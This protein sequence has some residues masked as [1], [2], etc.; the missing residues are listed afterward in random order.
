MINRFRLGVTESYLC[1]VN[2][3][4]HFLYKVVWFYG[5]YLKVMDEDRVS[6]SFQNYISRVC[7][8]VKRLVGFILRWFGGKCLARN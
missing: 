5:S 3:Q 6:N 4:D 7:N 2:P 8:F 1:N